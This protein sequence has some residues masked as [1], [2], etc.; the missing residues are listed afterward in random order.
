[1]A[2]MRILCIGGLHGFTSTHFVRK[3]A[4]R[5]H[6]VTV[7]T[8]GTYTPPPSR[9]AS[10]P[11]GIEVLVGD[12]HDNL[13]WAQN[14]EWDAAVDFWGLDAD[15]VTAMAG[16][17]RG[18]IGHY[19]MISSIAVYRPD[20]AVLD[21]RSAVLESHDLLNVSATPKNYEIGRAHV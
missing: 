19:T 1:M 7:L 9:E 5:G 20:P 13:D 11:D 17:L 4:E 3:A 14:R 2:P 10:L 16:V 15:S 8:R 21:E 18:R 12:R 6:Q